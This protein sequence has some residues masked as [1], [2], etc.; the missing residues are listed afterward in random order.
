MGT[1][2]GIAVGVA[3]ATPI[4]AF[5]TT[6]MDKATQKLSDPELI[7]GVFTA[8][9]NKTA[10]IAPKVINKTAEEAPSIIKYVFG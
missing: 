2:M 8:I 5:I 1:I 4:T 3:F 7:D 6:M 9:A 10:E